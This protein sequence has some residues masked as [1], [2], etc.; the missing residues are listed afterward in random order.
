MQTLGNE[1]LLSNHKI[2]FLCSRRYPAGVVLKA[3]DWAVE[4]REG[5]HCVISG[6][7]STLEKDVFDILLKGEQPL[8]MA[9]ARGMPKRFPPL[10][11]Q[12]I[13]KGRPLVISPFPENISRPTARTCASRNQYIVDIAD[14]IIVAYASKGGALE[15]LLLQKDIFPKK[16]RIFSAQSPMYYDNLTVTVKLSN[17]CCSFI[18]QKTTRSA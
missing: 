12:A 3:Y 10:V 4:Q 8:I 13:E 5:G 16:S 9:R 6:F 14:E 7:H 1:Q 17:T 11:K 18:N 15:K 2:A